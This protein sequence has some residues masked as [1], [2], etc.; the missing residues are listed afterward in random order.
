MNTR[1]VYP[2]NKFHVETIVS[3]FQEAVVKMPNEG[4]KKVRTYYIPPGQESSWFGR[5]IGKVSNT[6]QSMTRKMNPFKRTVGGSLAVVAHYNK[7]REYS[8]EVTKK[9]IKIFKLVG[10]FGKANKS[11]L[12]EEFL[13][14]VQVAVHD[15]YYKLTFKHSEIYRALYHLYSTLFLI[16]QDME[17]TAKMG[18]LPDTLSEPHIVILRTIKEKDEGIYDEE[19][20]PYVG[21]FD[22]LKQEAEDDLHE[23][24]KAIKEVCLE[25]GGENSMI[26]EERGKMNTLLDRIT[27]VISLTGSPKSASAH[28]GAR[29]TKRNKQSKKSQKSQKSQSIKRLHRRM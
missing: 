4:S 8:D 20:T 21:M 12:P 29:K 11:W 16:Q 17:P 23:F 15:P 2:N 26:N 24:V 28:G 13:K 10:S 14:K 27:A 6:F 7:L 9:K 5:T 25:I 1:E 22:T 3:P 19:F 18:P